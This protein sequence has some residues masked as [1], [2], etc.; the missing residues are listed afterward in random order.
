MGTSD[1]AVPVFSRLIDSC[2]CP[3]LLV[4]Q[5]ERR[6]GRRKSIKLELIE[7]A[8]E[9][10]IPIFQ[11]E[12]IN[13][14][15]SLAYISSFAPDVIIT[16]SFGSIL[17]KRLRDIPFHNCLNIHPSLLPK[18]R[19]AAPVNFPLL[20]G[21]KETGVSIF[22]MKAKMDTGP[23]LAQRTIPIKDDDF[24]TKLQD[25][26]SKAGA[27]MLIETLAG[28]ENGR[29]IPISQKHQ[30]ASYTRKI[31]KDDLIIDWDRPA[32]VIV[33]QIKAFAETPGA[34]TTFRGSVLKIISAEKY[35][36][37]SSSKPGTVYEVLKKEG[38]IVSVGLNESILIKNVQPAGKKIMTAYDFNLGARI[39]NEEFFE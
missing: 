5:P 2:Y 17:G 24:Y 35:P 31:E 12:N 4:T 26:L 11:P 20:N 36:E 27:E 28:L 34:F 18:Y 23:I 16:A 15:E 6:S 14:E 30:F 3:A 9:N 32:E 25:N 10:N 19:G 37:H 39:K 1:F 22:I 13:S 7:L 33:N 8:K 21:D 38:L 29:V